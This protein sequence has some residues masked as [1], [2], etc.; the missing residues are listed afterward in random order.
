MVFSFLVLVKYVLKENWVVPD[1]ILAGTS[2][3]ILYILSQ[4]IVS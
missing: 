2:Y 3:Q 4:Q 1:P